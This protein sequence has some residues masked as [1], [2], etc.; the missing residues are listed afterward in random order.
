MTLFAAGLV[1][2]FRHAPTPTLQMLM[3]SVLLWVID[4]AVRLYRRVRGRRFEVER[5]EPLPGNATLLVL[6]TDGRL[7]HAGGQWAYLHLQGVPSISAREA[8]PFSIASPP[9]AH[10][11]VWFI[12]KRGGG[13]TSF[14]NR[15]YKTAV[16][17]MLSPGA[18]VELDGPYGELGLRPTDPPYRI[19]FLIAGGIGITPMAPPHA[20]APH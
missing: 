1:M 12:I 17:G 7:Q 4:H 8:H 19:V 20:P 3:P 16:G 2:V 5:L 11:T 14:T 13:P 15:L 9:G 18:R 6:K 10:A